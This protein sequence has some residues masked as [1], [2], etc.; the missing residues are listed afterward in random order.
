MIPYNACFADGY[1]ICIRNNQNRSLYIRQIF[2]IQM[3]YRLQTMYNRMVGQVGRAA[4]VASS[5]YSILLATITQKYIYR[6]SK[7][8]GKK[9]DNGHYFLKVVF[10]RLLNNLP[11]R[12]YLSLTIDLLNH[13][14]SIVGS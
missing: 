4:S 5:F 13:I 1:S 14:F 8:K 9:L 6:S 3:Q 7:V 11:N 2:L 10:D 12:T